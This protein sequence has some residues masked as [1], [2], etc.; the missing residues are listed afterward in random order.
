M[1]FLTDENIAS[2]VI[3]IIRKRGFDVKDIK[4]ERF[5]GFDDLRIID[6]ANKEN[7]IIITH[8][9]DFAELITKHEHKGVILIKRKKQTPENTLILL[10]RVLDS[11]LKDKI[12]ENL[13][14][15]TENK[16]SIHTN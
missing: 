11:N 12:K 14:I 10:M 4:E 3:N 13:V 16:I 1:K 7:R 6:I 15:V 8:D 9:K 5:Y 2:S